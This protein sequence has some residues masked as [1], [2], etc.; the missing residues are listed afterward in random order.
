MAMGKRKATAIALSAFLLFPLAVQAEEEADVW[1]KGMEDRMRLLEDKLV[2]SE[3]TI[4]AQADLIRSQP[5]P[6]VSEGGAL[7]EFL[8]GLQWG[9]HVTGSYVHNFNRPDAQAG[10][11]TLC[12]FNCDH[13]S[14]KLDA[15]KIELGKE[16]M[17]PGTAG[18]QLDLLWGENAS[19]LGGYA[20]DSDNFSYV[21]EAYATYNWDGTQLRTSHFESQT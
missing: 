3:A 19:I 8:N 7:S 16:A 15:A 6:D 4:E 2:A 13:E 20:G 21:Q 14:F 1:M 17:E 12:Q 9:G 11:Q 18:F 10:S 5:G